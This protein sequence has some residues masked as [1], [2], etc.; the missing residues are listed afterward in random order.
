M[1]NNQFWDG[2]NFGVLLIMLVAYVIAT[3]ANADI[4]WEESYLSLDEVGTGTLLSKKGLGQELGQGHG[5]QAFDRTSAKFDVDISGLMASVRLQQTFSN[6]SSDWT[7]AIYVLPLMDNSA[8]H[9]MRIVVGERVIEGQI[10][11]RS[12]AK[13]SYTQA[14][15]RVRRRAYWSR[16]GPTYLLPK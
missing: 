7:E 11:E 1:S 14:K 12:E 15:S 8:V 5:Y 10:K 6:T 16:I 13:R 4:Q 3:R 2:R 9:A